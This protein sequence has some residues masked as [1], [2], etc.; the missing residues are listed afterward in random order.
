MVHTHLYP[1]E[2]GK[3]AVGS[4]QVAEEVKDLHSIAEIPSH[5]HSGV[6]A[7][8]EQH[9]GIQSQLSG[10]ESPSRC[11]PMR[12]THDQDSTALPAGHLHQVVQAQGKPGH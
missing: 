12:T 1:G 4:P 3:A 2:E 9:A 7:L 6:C 8:W 5:R 11:D 10:Q